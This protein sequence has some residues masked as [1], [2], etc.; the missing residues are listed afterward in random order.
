MDGASEM[1]EEEEDETRN[2][3]MKRGMGTV[4]IIIS[5]ELLV[6]LGGHL[7]RLHLV[8]FFLS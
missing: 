1:D 5:V 6:H 4:Y 2:G 3:K 8:Q 7:P